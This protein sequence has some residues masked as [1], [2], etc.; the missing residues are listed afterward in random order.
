M[1]L[2]PYIIIP[3]V[4][5]FLAQWIK[6]SIAAYK[7]DI[8]F[9]YLYASGGMPSVHSAVV[10]SLFAT[11]LLQQGS[12]SPLTG[13]TG[14]LAAI[15]I[16]DSLGVRRST[17][18]Q[19]IV[20]NALVDGLE[21]HK[22]S[23]NNNV[24]KVREVLGHKPKEV[25]WGML[26]GVLVAII[27]NLEKLG[28]QFDFLAV[29]PKGNE[30]YGYVAV[31]AVMLVGVVGI[32]AR[33]GKRWSK[34]E[35]QN[36]KLLAWLT[37]TIVLGGFFI[38]LAAHEEVAVLGSRW[39]IYAVIILTIS[40]VAYVVRSVISLPATNKEVVADRKKRWLEKGK[41]KKRKK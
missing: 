12:M 7:D 34:A 13:V 41:K 35:G 38:L 37:I 2:N 27:G 30:L 15:V 36:G 32:L 26:L 24:T 40:M 17:G 19:A 3:F 4:A 10:T 33:Y 6:F 28:K 14:I 11:T 18:E 29:I 1:Q 5:W 39:P 31:L 20:L 23:F 21:E 25:F 16:Y 8:N 9:R 22:I